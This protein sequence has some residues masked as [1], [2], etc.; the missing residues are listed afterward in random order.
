MESVWVVGS[1]DQSHSLGE[2][3]MAD[4]PAACLFCNVSEHFEQGSYL[5]RPTLR[6]PCG[7]AGNEKINSKKGTKLCCFA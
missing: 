6:S 7:G 4:H 2:K 1:D 3:A 5:S